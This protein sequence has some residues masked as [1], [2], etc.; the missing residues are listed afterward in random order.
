MTSDTPLLRGSLPA[1]VTPSR[2]G[3]AARNLPD[4]AAR[5]PLW[6]GWRRTERGRFCDSPQ[7]AAR[8]DLLR[9]LPDAVTAS[10]V[11]APPLPTE[12]AELDGTWLLGWLN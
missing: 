12:V 1:W 2:I 8:P 7:V 3:T 4:A 11:A 9:R 5:M 6:R 10:R